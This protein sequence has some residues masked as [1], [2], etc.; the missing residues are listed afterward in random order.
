[1][2]FLSKRLQKLVAVSGTAAALAM[3]FSTTVAHA[4]GW[5][6]ILN[7]AIMT[8]AMHDIYLENMLS[9]GDNPY[10][11]NKILKEDINS[12]GKCEDVRA[13]AVVNDVMSRLI[14]NGN[15]ALKA[16]SLP[17]RWEV[18]QSEEINA[19]CYYNDY[20]TI[21]KG[22][23]T[24]YNYNHDMLAEVLAHEMMHGI[25]QHTAHSAAN[26]IATRYAADI[27]NKSNNNELV[28][29]LV[30]I[31]TNYQCA[32]NYTAP[33]EVEADEG[34][35]F[36][37]TSAGFNPGAFAAAEQRYFMK[38]G[39]YNETI[40]NLN[41]HPTTSNRVKRGLD[42]MKNYSAGHVTIK[43]NPDNTNLICIDEQPFY[44]NA[45]N[46]QDLN[47]FEFTA[48]VAGD[49]AKAFHE[50]KFSTLWHF[51]HNATGNVAGFLEGEK[52]DYKY[53]KAAIKLSGADLANK[54]ENMVDNAYNLE[55][56]GSMRIKAFER[57]ENFKAKMDNNRKDSTTDDGYKVNNYATNANCY[58][59]IG[60]PD[61]AEFEANRALT[62]NPNH[63]RAYA[64]KADAYRLRGD[65]QKAVQYFDKAIACGYDNSWSHTYRGYTMLKLGNIDEA[66][67]EAK[68]A[69]N[70][71]NVGPK[72][73]PFLLAGDIEKNTNNE[74]G[75]LSYYRQAVS[76]DSNAINSIPD[77]Y[78]DKVQ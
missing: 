33:S 32:K 14:E 76:I 34:G 52:Y 73:L 38:Y 5:V 7:G 57:E 69:Q 56:K 13:N 41:D 9:L 70:A 19:A 20:I 75:A 31:V 62:V 74:A 28:S 63:G 10:D 2:E 16:N 68:L 8:S 36:I 51:R 65:Y 49:L 17:F 42:W 47:N 48:F 3:P 6:D 54:L 24:F 25:C 67:K 11:Q 43:S 50:H 12:K 61:L 30:N 66:R 44:V 46:Y 35:Y 15:Y 22:I 77:K 60:L 26:V 72:F 58:N 45:T 18:N 27:F 55:R 78:K 37:M 40:T 53:L 71:Q 64:N 21:N 59:V 1:M 23:V 39:D 4:E 29:M